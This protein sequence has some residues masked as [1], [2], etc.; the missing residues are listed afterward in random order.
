M[1]HRLEITL[2]PDLF[3]AEGEKV[4]QKAEDYLGIKLEKVRTV[5]VVIID[6][7]FTKDQLKTVQREVFTNPVTQISSFDPLDLDFDWTIWVGF[8]AGV[9]DNPGSTAIEAIEDV[10][11]IDFSEKDAVYTSRRY[12]L[13]GRDLTY[14]DVDKIAGEL[15][16]ND[17]IQQWKVFPKKTW[18][19]KNGIGLIL[20]KV[21]LDHEPTVATIPVD[22]D[23]AL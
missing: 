3:D 11:K 22:S 2:R 17:I 13:Q 6:A 10:F 23:A 21:K 20:P 8:R 1:A 15:L 19:P 14:E 9:R 5:Q 18:D 4:R 7:D 12:C 16:A